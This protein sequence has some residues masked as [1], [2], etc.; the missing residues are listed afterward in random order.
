MAAFDFVSAFE[1]DAHSFGVDAMLFGENASGERSFSVVVEHA[2]GGLQ[3]NRAGVEIF[4]HEMHGAAGEFHS[5][6][7][8]LALGLQARKRR[9]ERWVNI[10]NAIGKRSHE[11]RREQPHVSGEADEIDLLLAEDGDDL[12]VVGFALET[13]GGNDARRDF[14][15]LSLVNARRAFTVANDHGDF[16]IGNAAVGD[17]VREGLEVRAAAAQQHGYALGHEQRKLDRKSVV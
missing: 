7:E 11:K 9:Q 4:V 14:A 16:G 13:F 17:A 12:A 5:I 8:R 15:L 2:N 10:Q 1:D 3:Y 6:L